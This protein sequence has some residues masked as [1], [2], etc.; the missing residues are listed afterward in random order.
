MVQDQ[1][2]ETMMLVRRD[3][4][5]ESERR[6]LPAGLVDPDLTPEAARAGRLTEICLIDSVVR[7]A[8]AVFL[9]SDDYQKVQQIKSELMSKLLMECLAAFVHHRGGQVAYAIR[10]GDRGEVINAV[11]SMVSSRSGPRLY[12]E[13]GFLFVYF[14]DEKVVISTEALATHSGLGSQTTVRS[15]RDSASFWLEWEKYARKHSYLRGQAFFADGQIIERARKYTWDNIL[16]AETARRLIRV[17]VEG[18][19]RNREALRSCGV[20][21][22]RG[23]ILSGPPG[24]GKTLLGKVLADTL[25]GASFMWVSPRHV[26]NPAS[27]QEILEVARFTAP[28]VVFLEDLDLFAEERD[29]GGGMCLGQLMNELDGAVDN[30]DLITIATTNRLE[31]IEKALRNRPGRFDRVIEMNAMDDLCRRKLLLKLTAKAEVSTEDMNYLVDATLDYTGAQVEEL[32]NTLYILG[33]D[34]DNAWRCVSVAADEVACGP[35][36]STISVSR[37]LID[38]A[39][40]E[41]R[42]ERK[43]KM[44]FHAA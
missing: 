20:K 28:T 8:V 12:L 30:E 15:S 19:L 2:L 9:E 34:G 1:R 26:R 3:L 35:A 22:R 36:P 27:F 32:A 43:A 13:W 29:S 44:G 31:V 37:Q 10:L 40:E 5:A 39:L 41:M 4:D 11:Q 6:D 17:H 7:R 25:E 23:L 42:V 21:A 16:L 33:V 14:P 18:F 38:A 24:T